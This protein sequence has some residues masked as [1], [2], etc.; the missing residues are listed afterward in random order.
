MPMQAVRTLR[1]SSAGGPDLGPRL[2]MGGVASV[3]GNGYGAS[4]GSGN[5][6]AQAG[7]R[8]SSRLS[9]VREN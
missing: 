8:Q 6:L 4:S 5:G 3:S 9:Q 1:E 7:R 2:S